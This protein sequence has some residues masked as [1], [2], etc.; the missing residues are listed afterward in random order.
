[1]LP[2]I[3][4]IVDNF[5][6]LEEWEDRHQ[7]LMELGRKLPPMPAEARSD[8]NKVRGCVSQ[9]WLETLVDRSDGTPRL[10]FLGDSDAHITKG[11]VAV[12]I[13]FFDGRT[14]VDAARA[15]ALG[16]FQQLGLSE[17]LTAQ[18][19][20]GARAMMERIRSD[21]ARLAA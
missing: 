6:F 20:N 2:P 1:M 15:D 13:A 7:Y 9:V 4:E 3:A 11:V 17:H 18:R 5:A 19:S 21:A 10:H 12:L 14:A 8:A 16:L